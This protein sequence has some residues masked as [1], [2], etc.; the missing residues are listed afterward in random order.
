MKYSKISVASEDYEKVKE[1]CK[2]NDQ[3]FSK[4]F[5]QLATYLSENE[6]LFFPN[7]L[8]KKDAI[9]ILTEQDL[10]E[11]GKVVSKHINRLVGFIKKQDEN[12]DDIRQEVR[13]GNKQILYKV[14]PEEEHIYSES[15][16]LFGDYEEIINTLKLLLINKGIDKVNFN[17][18]LE[19]E[20]EKELGTHTLKKYIDS[21]DRVIKKNFLLE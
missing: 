12:I 14:I 3:S 6:A 20:I 21:N 5:S 11:I 18:N 13:R 1:I 19:R 8:E 10:N 9:E 7:E 2:K 15:H 4:V 17:E 16:P